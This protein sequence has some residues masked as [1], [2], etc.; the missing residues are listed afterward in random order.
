MLTLSQRSKLL[1]AFFLV[2]FIW[3]STY[4]AIRFAVE[5]IPPFL[6]AGTRFLLAGVLMF[7]FLRWRGVAAPPWSQ[8]WRLGIVGLFLFLGGNGLVAWAEQS[9]D[10][11]L[12]AL[13]VSLLPLWL[14]VLDWLWAG[15]PAPT[16]RGLLGIAFGVVGTALLLAPPALFNG[17][18]VADDL[19]SLVS[20]EQAS[21]S[22]LPSLL[23]VGISGGV[24]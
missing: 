21:G 2:Y 15:G 16:L 10:S 12:A 4:L 13:L 8:W 17:A 19:G 20:A 1:T 11:G 22:L 14:I 18:A 5:T 9:I 3:G 6:M 24:S 7:V 23:S